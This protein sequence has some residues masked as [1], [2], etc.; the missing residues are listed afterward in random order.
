MIRYIFFFLT[1]IAFYSCKTE[2]KQVSNNSTS[3]ESTIDC[4]PN[5]PK[6]NIITTNE[7][8]ISVI[9]KK[10]STEGMLFIPKGNFT[11]GANNEQARNDEYPPHNVQI[12]GF[13]MD[14]T[15]V[16][17]AE[18][19]AFVEATG[20]I[21]YAERVPDWEEMKK[22]LPPGTQKPH[23]SLLTAG[24][25]VFKPAPNR[26]NLNDYSQW[27]EWK[28]NANW[29]QPQGPGS[30]IEGKDNY[31]VVHICWFD[32]VAYA[33][34]AGKRLPTEAEWE[35][36]SRGGLEKNIYPWGNEGINE[37][38]SKANSWEGEFPHQNTKKDQHY[39]AAPVKSYAPNGYGLY[40]MA[41]NVWEW[42]NDKYDYDYYKRFK[43]TTAINPK[44]P[45]KSY[46]PMDP[47]TPN[48]VQ[49]GGSFLCND[50]YCSGYRTASR[51]KSSPDTGLLHAGFRCVSDA[52]KPN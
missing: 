50:V 11:M 8:A 49:R 1:S 24:S 29:K 25:L 23:D 12:D 26:V 44:G 18:F 41:G 30:T 36:A 28:N 19:R 35:Y 7:D 5:I 46:D 31:P 43:N 9:K 17:N 38:K 14:E 34:W 40:D 2:T 10:P 52:P 37:G 45:E 21:T 16:T 39:Y 15:E 33:T 4:K 20:Y 13:W 3:K 47:Y 6:R 42:C 48:R 32:A 22:Q 51:M 27:W